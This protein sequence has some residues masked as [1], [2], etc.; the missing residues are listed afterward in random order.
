MEVLVDE[1]LNVGCQYMLA[2]QKASCIP[3]SI[4]R[5]IA[6]RLRKV[7]LPLMRP[8]LEYYIQ[9]VSPN[10]RRMWACWSEPRRG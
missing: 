9:E 4:K 5:S 3:G 2:V 10:R 1:K 6:S 7:I 8:Q